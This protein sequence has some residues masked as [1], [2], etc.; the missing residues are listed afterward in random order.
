MEIHFDV[1]FETDRSIYTSLSYQLNNNGTG[2][3]SYGAFLGMCCLT[4]LLYKSLQS[5]LCLD[6]MGCALECLSD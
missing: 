6:S 4:F 1:I 2:V 5:N 3:P